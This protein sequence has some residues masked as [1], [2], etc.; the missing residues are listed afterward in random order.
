MTKCGS[1]SVVNSDKPLMTRLGE[2]TEFVSDFP[3][4]SLLRVMKKSLG[5]E[6]SMEHHKRVSI[7]VLR[8]ITL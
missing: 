8:L 1:H 2:T 4:Y 6:I 7:N 3:T 5:W